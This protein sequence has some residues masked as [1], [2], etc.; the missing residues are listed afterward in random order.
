MKPP[1]LTDEE[2]R[3][4]LAE[5]CMLREQELLPNSPEYRNNIT[6]QNVLSRVNPQDV[7]LVNKVAKAQR[8]KEELLKHTK[9]LLY[10]RKNSRDGRSC[11]D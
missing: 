5:D 8:D 10:S 7:R 4:I 11:L 2:I 6:P 9:I 3:I 1:L